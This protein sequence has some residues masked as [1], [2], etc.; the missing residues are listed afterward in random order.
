MVYTFFFVFAKFTRARGNLG[1]KNPK[2][3][4]RAKLSTNNGTVLFDQFGFQGDFSE[5]FSSSEI[6][7]KYS[8]KSAQKSA[9]VIVR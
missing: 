3:F 1:L 9:T 4:S 5:L 7:F 2:W 8:W 6:E